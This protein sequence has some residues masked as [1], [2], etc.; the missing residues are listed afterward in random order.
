MALHAGQSSSGGTADGTPALPVSSALLS[1]GYLRWDSVTQA[2][3]IP[4]KQAGDRLHIN[5]KIV[6]ITPSGFVRALTAGNNKI[7]STGTDSGGLPAA[8]ETLYAYVSN[9]DAS[10]SPLSLRYSSTTA[11]I[12]LGAA[13]EADGYWAL[14]TTGNARNWRYVGLLLFDSAAQVKRDTNRNYLFSFM[15]PKRFFGRIVSGY[16]NNDADTTYTVTGAGY[17][18]PTGTDDYHEFFHHPH[19][20][21]RCLFVV[22]TSANTAEL[23]FGIE[24]GDEGGARSAGIIPISTT[25]QRGVAEL[26][27]PGDETLSSGALSKFQMAFLHTPG[28]ATII[29]DLVRNGG[30]A[31]PAATY[32]D[33]E[34]YR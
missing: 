32:M 21:T 24:N 11:P 3:F 18:A 8:T 27:F 2:T 16:N 23:R 20:G 34:Y 29:A 31:D 22:Q 19:Y 30:P 13:G 6:T 26:A 12:A 25:P 5:N 28:S 1:G 4:D 15:N 9:A 17:G 7:T 33:V 10:F 14:G